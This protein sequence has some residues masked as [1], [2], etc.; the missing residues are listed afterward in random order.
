MALEEIM[1]EVTDVLIS[2]IESFKSEM[3]EVSVP[4][5]F[6][7]DESCVFC[8]SSVLDNLLVTANTVQPVTIPLLAFSIRPSLLTEMAYLSE[9]E[10]SV[11]AV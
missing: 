7:A 10:M 11:P 5:R 3:V 9:I 2:I 6:V 8:V 4:I 1:A